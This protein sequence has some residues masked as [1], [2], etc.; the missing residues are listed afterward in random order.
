MAMG[1]RAHIWAR[2]SMSSESFVNLKGV[3]ISLLSQ[4]HLS[5]AV[6]R[7]DHSIC[8]GSQGPV[9]KLYV[10]GGCERWVDMVSML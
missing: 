5:T 10:A 6:P 1:S 7:F 4:P 9:M 2:S 3:H 8:F